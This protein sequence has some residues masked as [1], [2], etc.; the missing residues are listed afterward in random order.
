MSVPGHSAKREAARKQDC[1][2]TDS[3]I[4]NSRADSKS[5]AICPTNRSA[6]SCHRRSRRPNRTCGDASRLP[7]PRHLVSS[8][9]RRLVSSCRL[10]R[11]CFVSRHPRLRQ[12]LRLR[13]R[14]LHPRHLRLGRRRLHRHLSPP[15][16]WAPRL[17]RGRALRSLWP[18]SC[19]ELPECTLAFSTSHAGARC[20]GPTSIARVAQKTCAL[21]HEAQEAVAELLLRRRKH[22]SSWR[23]DW[24]S[25]WL[26]R[27]VARLGANVT[28]PPGAGR[29]RAG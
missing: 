11:H 15:R 16:R 22:R 10:R 8:C 28:L 26:C 27:A 2:S 3:T 7:C 6:S 13:D 18:R 20:T 14:R 9:C 12:D 24:P 17:C 4:S 21:L 19:C 5:Y 29:Q 1:I 25:E 23:L